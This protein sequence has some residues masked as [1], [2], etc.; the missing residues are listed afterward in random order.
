[1]LDQDYW[2]TVLCHYHRHL[3]RSVTQCHISW[4]PP[5]VVVVAR[6]ARTHWAVVPRHPVTIP[7]SAAWWRLHWPAQC[8][9]THAIRSSYYCLAQHY[10]VHYTPSNTFSGQPKSTLFKTKQFL[11]SNIQ[12]FVLRKWLSDKI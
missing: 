4:E 1:M 9:H 2:F 3:S 8:I 6:L 5:C 7:A 11:A 10:T 12:R